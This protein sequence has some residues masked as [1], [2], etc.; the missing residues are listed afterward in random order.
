MT[1]LLGQD[2]RVIHK[3]YDWGKDAAWNPIWSTAVDRTEILDDELSI[4]LKNTKP[5]FLALFFERK[6][7]IRFANQEDILAFGRF[8]LPESLDPP[9]DGR[10]IPWAE[11]GAPVRP[12][13]FNVR[14]DHFVAR[15]I[16]PDGTW[17][18]VGAFIQV[19]QNMV[20]TFQTM[21]RAWTYV[22][23]LQAI[24]PGD[25]VEVR[26][27][28][29]VPYD[30]NA[31]HTRGWR[32]FQW[33]DNWARS[34][35]WRIF[36]HDELPILHQQVSLRYHVKHGLSF[37][38][39][40]FYDLKEDGDVTTV[41]WENH[42][43]PGCM[44]EVNA[45]P[46]ADLPH[47]DV[48]L[49]P[50]DLR[51][52]RRDRVS[53]LPFQQPYWLYVLRRREE[54]AI[55]WQRVGMKNLPDRQNELFN[56]FVER[57]TIGIPEEAT[58]QKME[59]LHNYIAEHFAYKNDSLWYQELDLK[60][61][62]IGDQVSDERIREISRYDLYS[63]M[64]HGVN[65]GYST[66]YLM[67]ERIGIMDDGWMTP[68]W[69]SD[70]LIGVKDDQQ[71]LWMHPKRGPVGLWANE[72]PFYW[73]GTSALLMTSELLVADIPSPPLFLELPEAMPGM[74]VRVLETDLQVATGTGNSRARSRVL[75]S[76]QFSTLGRSDYLLGAMD[77]QVD[78]RYGA[79]LDGALLKGDGAWQM[80]SNA[81]VAP[82]RFQA[83]RD[84][85]FNGS[86]LIEGNDVR[87]LDLS[88]CIG[89]AAPEGF[90]ATDRD[91]PF[92]WD[93][94]QTDRSIIELHFDHPVEFLNLSDL[95]A[96]FKTPS[97][98]LVRTVTSDA[99]D[100]LRV[101]SLLQVHELREEVKD[102]AALQ[103]LIAAALAKDLVLKFRVP[104]GQP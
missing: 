91:L 98:D 50:E 9:Y 40:T 102:A 78:P 63:K 62:R 16:R 88:S 38:T 37:R 74:D 59:T 93:F 13:W 42:D 100:H 43:L 66:A 11:K 17:G 94:T 34:T 104:A 18:E 15:I 84:A 44:N 30:V 87:S 53:G 95:N 51:Y 31:N 46:G 58:A 99:P 29:M 60:L 7:V 45:R 2:T 52:W 41:T 76:G 90:L 6:Q 83:M 23:D 70:F 89:H 26:W 48:T 79:V 103:P 55:W 8:T 72:L 81:S 92:Y 20:R 24:A 33:M 56:E 12:L 36:F 65:A 54:R 32:G 19:D 28:Y 101:E 22:L 25:V 85:A 4:R 80:R 21:E 10:E 68:M 5:Q 35:S 86:V 61:A 96:T 67:D 73:Q 14:L 27:K 97:A 47:V 39:S 3:N 1:G 82:Y 57:T 71:V 77:P 49:A 64:V 75:L 69:D